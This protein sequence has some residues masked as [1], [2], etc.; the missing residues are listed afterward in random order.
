MSGMKIDIHIFMEFFL[1]MN[2]FYNKTWWL[3]D[4]LYL[5]TT[6]RFSIILEGMR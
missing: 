4:G 2:T 6:M 3:L 5:K 1:G